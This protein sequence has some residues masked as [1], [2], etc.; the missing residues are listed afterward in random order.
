LKFLFKIK[1][2]FKFFYFNLFVTVFCESESVSNETTLLSYFG[3][4]IRKWSFSLKET[5]KIHSKIQRNVKLLYFNLFVTVFSESE[6][7]SNETTILSYF[8]R[9]IRKWNFSLKE[10]F[11]LHFKIQWNVKL[12]YFNLFVT[13]FCE[14]EWV[15]Y[16]TTLHSYFGRY[17]RKWSFSLKEMFKIHSKI[18]RNVKFFYFNLFVTVFSESESVSNETSILS[19]FGRYISKWSF[20]LGESFKIHCKI[21]RN[22]KFLYSASLNRFQM[23]Q[24]SSVISGDI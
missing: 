12:L 9:Y 14:S 24:A 8:G 3:R 19:Y 11:Q 22:V 5:L 13:V 1:R 6:S 20:S 16:E 15:S 7:L 18:Q 21:Q 4:Y 17:I 10:T 23:N 2:N